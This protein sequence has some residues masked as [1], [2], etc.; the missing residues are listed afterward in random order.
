[1]HGLCA[2]EVILGVLVDDRELREDEMR[3]LVDG[4]LMDREQDGNHEMRAMDDV[5]RRD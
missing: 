2:T 3:V 4:G 1:M 5:E